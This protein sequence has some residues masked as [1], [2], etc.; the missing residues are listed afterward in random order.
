M[1]CNAS[2][3]GLQHTATHYNTLQHTAS[4]CNTLQHAVTH[5]NAL[6]RTAHCNSASIDRMY[7]KDL[8]ADNN[9]LIKMVANSLGGL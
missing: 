8:L 7:K 6:Q 5:C 2:I 3:D 4:H 1:S 9:A